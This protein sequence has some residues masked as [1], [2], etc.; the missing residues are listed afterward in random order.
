MQSTWTLK[1]LFLF[2][3]EL[4]YPP[5]PPPSLYSPLTRDSFLPGDEWDK[6][7]KAG[8]EEE[9]RAVRPLKERYSEEEEEEQAKATLLPKQMPKHT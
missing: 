1:V 6:K 2:C 9:E 5:P 8:A 3:S 4:W 7:E